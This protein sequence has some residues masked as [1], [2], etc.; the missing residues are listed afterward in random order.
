[1]SGPR[2]V[3]DNHVLGYTVDHEARS[4]VAADGGWP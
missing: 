2:S 4:I 3:H 1:M